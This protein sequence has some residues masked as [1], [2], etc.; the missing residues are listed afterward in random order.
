M[1]KKSNW[2]SEE[3]FI[4]EYCGEKYRYIANLREHYSNC[5]EKRFG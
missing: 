1:E 2:L 5:I 4:C 3:R